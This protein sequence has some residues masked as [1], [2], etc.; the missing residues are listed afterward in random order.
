MFFFPANYI[1]VH[2]SWAH[3]VNVYS[4]S[5]NTTL[6]ILR[7]LFWFHP[8]LPNTPTTQRKTLTPSTRRVELPSFP[9]VHPRPPSTFTPLICR[10]CC[11]NRLPGSIRLSKQRCYTVPA[12]VINIYDASPPLLPPPV[13]SFSPC[14]NGASFRPG[15][16]IRQEWSGHTEHGEI[17]EFTPGLKGVLQVCETIR[18]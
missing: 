13:F 2:P 3:D 17:Q 10:S 4:F 9:P 6:Q 8:S 11:L 12:R 14:L 1:S 15:F 18:S 7:I 5:E 16:H